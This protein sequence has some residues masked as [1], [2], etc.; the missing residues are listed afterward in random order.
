MMWKTNGMKNSE[1]TDSELKKLTRMEFCFWNTAH[2]TTQDFQILSSGTNIVE[3]E[4]INE[5]VS[6]INWTTYYAKMTI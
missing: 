5:V 4:N 6:G 1:T 2:K 3:L